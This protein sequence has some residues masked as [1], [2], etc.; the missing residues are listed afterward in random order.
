[1]HLHSLHT[2]MRWLAHHASSYMSGGYASSPRARPNEWGQTHTAYRIVWNPAKGIGGFFSNLV[3]CV[4]AGI[5]LQS[6]TIGSRCTT[7]R[8]G[9]WCNPRVRLHLRR[10]KSL[11]NC[12]KKTAKTT[13]ARIIMFKRAFNT[14]KICTFVTFL[15]SFG[16]KFRLVWWL[17]KQIARY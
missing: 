14:L 15:G 6:N 8:S 2:A 7:A 13:N 12:L 9:L 3:H 16:C 1:M 11:Y 10:Q 17:V 4:G 5:G